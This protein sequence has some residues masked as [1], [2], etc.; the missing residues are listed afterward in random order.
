MVINFAYD[1]PLLNHGFM[2]ISY[3]FI[4]LGVAVGAFSGLVGIGGGI[5]AI[6]ALT[7]LFGFSQQQAQG[8]SLAMMLPPVGILA[9]W[10]YY[11]HGYVDIKAAALL[12]IGFLIG[13]Y[14]GAKLAV[15]LPTAVI[16]KIFAVLLLIIGIKMLASK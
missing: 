9:V 2:M 5:I 3:L 13:G 12:A 10:A 14:F 16:K 15:T 8:T 1:G 4:L 6:P 7:M 11:T